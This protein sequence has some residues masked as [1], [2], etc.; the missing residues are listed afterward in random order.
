MS[1]QHRPIKRNQNASNDNQYYENQDFGTVWLSEFLSYEKA[2]NESIAKADL[3]NFT[4]LPGSTVHPAAE[5]NLHQHSKSVKKQ[6]EKKQPSSM[7]ADERRRLNELSRQLNNKS[8]SS[9]KTKSRK[10]RKQ[11]LT[12]YVEAN[13]KISRVL[14][15]VK[16]RS[17]KE[18]MEARKLNDF[19]KLVKRE[20]QAAIKIQTQCRRVLATKK[21]R[22]FQLE[23][24]SATLLESS[25]RMLLAKRLLQRLKERKRLATMIR[26]RFFRLYIARFRR[27]KRIQLEHA[28]ATL[29][30][31]S[32]R[33]FFAKCI[34]DKRRRQYSWEINQQRWRAL[35]TRLAWKDLRINF[36]AR[37]IQCIARRG[38]AKARV[39]KLFVL[40]TQSAT[41]IQCIWRRT[42]AKILKADIV[43]RATVEKMKNKIRVIASEK[44]Y[45]KQ[46]IEEL[47][48]PSK[49]HRLKDLE[50]QKKKLEDEAKEKEEQ[51]N[52]LESYYKDQ[53][54]LQEQLTPRAISNGW[55][56]QLKI[57]LK[58]TR[59]RITVAKLDLMFRIHIGLKKAKHEL[60]ILEAVNLDAKKSLDHWSNWNQA[61]Q[62][63]LWAFQRQHN[64]DIEGRELRH[65][66]VNE[67]LKWQVK[68]CRLSGKPD[69]RKLLV[70]DP[71][72]NEVVQHLIDNVK[73]KADEFQAVQHA[74]HCFQP[75]QRFWDTISAAAT[76]FSSVAVL[77]NTAKMNRAA[78]ENTAARD[79]KTNEKMSLNE[80]SLHPHTAQAFPSK[81]P[82]HLL[83]K[84]RKERNDIATSLKPK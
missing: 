70:N 34:L 39:R 58:D 51:I 12:P 11:R 42:A 4:K 46:Q 36:H 80:A 60:N 20:S 62:D 66:I 21:A 55:E 61:E 6:A 53:L 13:A 26:E 38:L 81:L 27:R 24:K 19:Y 9:I 25:V 16:L 15:H 63:R 18:D 2:R 56:E 79:E 40:C 49:V 30:Q 14:K 29:V 50:A 69:K 32:V 54:E 1:P 82:F 8:R 5:K 17:N 23:V 45:W 67:Q 59:E 33:M 22:Q 83:E 43:Y 76:E 44:E 68:H 3:L 48:K 37:Q 47:E 52:T 41:V 84:M 7:S 72:E 71:V 28:S 31:S 57:N 10:D 77:D 78:S 74:E 64:R 73:S 65:A 35:S 75:F